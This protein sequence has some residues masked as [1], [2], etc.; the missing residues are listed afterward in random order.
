MINRGEFESAAQAA[1]ALADETPKRDVT[2]LSLMGEIAFRQHRDEAAE[3][4]FRDALKLAPGFAD[5]HYGLSLVMLARAEPDPALRHAQFALNQGIAEPR[6][7]AQLGHCQLELGNFGQAA[8]ALAR[9]TRLDPT[10]RS[11]WNN[12]GIAA[13]AHGD[14]TDARKAFLRALEIDPEFA[15]ARANLERLDADMIAAGVTKV[16]TGITNNDDVPSRE[17][18]E[19]LAAVRSLADAGQIDGAIDACELLGAERPDDSASVIELFRLYRDRG[20]AQSGL[21]ALEAFRQRHPDNIDVVAELGKALVREH[22]FKRAKPLLEQALGERPDDVALLLGMVDV[23]VEQ[24]RFADAGELVERAYAI[25]SGVHMKGRLAASLLSRC[26]YERALEVLEEMLAEAPRAADSVLGIKVDALTHL[27][28]HDEALPILDRYLEKHPHESGRRFPRATIHL[29][30]ERFGLG[31]DDYAYRNLGSVKHL[32][33]VAFPQWQGEPLAGKRILVLAEQGLGDQ[34]MFASCLPDLL[35]QQP[36]RVVVEAVKRVAPTLARSFPSCE[37]IS[38]RQDSDLDWVRDIG[39][40]D[41]FVPIGD[42]PQRFRRD[43][44]HF[45]RHTGYLVADPQR[46]AHWRDRLAAL[47]PRP[48]IGVSWRGG[49]EMTRKVLRTMDAA[50]LAG[51]ASAIDAD[52]VCLQYGDVSDGLSQAGAQGMRLNYWPEAITD[53][54]E[55]A[56]L[57]SALDLVVTVCNTTVHYAGAL[58]KPVWVLAPRIPEWR[59]GLRF[60]SM[61]WYPSS[62]MYRQDRDGDWNAVLDAVQRDLK[63][64]FSSHVTAPAAEILTAPPV[65]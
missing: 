65:G 28:R 59:Y 9:A 14:W 49:T 34:V 11:S 45:P 21:D 44:A 56:A 52:W 18:D 26:L 2:A 23:R 25:D 39:D 22:E 37:V 53:L 12:L 48:K 27:G 1:A 55:F 46:V 15:A 10:D 30:N 8:N 51:L 61:P 20:D 63:A 13:R 50:R 24:G 31:W 5:A 41:Y 16:S 7:N 64:Q 43:V 17:L 38:S 58:A 40:M 47:G 35:A 42:L 3:Q 36:A 29:L 54:D 4:Y 62:T 19:R 60:Q 33:M 57:I 6:F 32:R